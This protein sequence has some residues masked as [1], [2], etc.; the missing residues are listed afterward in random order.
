[1]CSL[2]LVRNSPC[3]SR[4]SPFSVSISLSILVDQKLFR[5]VFAGRKIALLSSARH[6]HIQRIQTVTFTNGLEHVNKKTPDHASHNPP[7]TPTTTKT[8]AAMACERAAIRVGL[9]AFFA[10]SRGALAQWSVVSPS[11]TALSDGEPPAS[12]DRRENIIEP[13]G[14]SSA[15]GASPALLQTNKFYSNYVV[16]SAVQSGSIVLRSSIYIE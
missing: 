11:T 5:S 7:P 6:Y 12:F 16:V 15:L 4:C 2:M 13:V 14:V 3:A 10:S 1:M 9:L 8:A